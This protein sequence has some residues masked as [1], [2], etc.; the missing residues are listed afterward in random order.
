M[1]LPTLAGI[2]LIVVGVIILLFGGSFTTRENVMEMGGMTVTVEERNPIL[3][4]VGG[5]AVIAGIGLVVMGARRQ[6]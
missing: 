2:G 5:I 6:A 3:P 4:W 1:R